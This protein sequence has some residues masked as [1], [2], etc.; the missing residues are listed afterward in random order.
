MSLDRS[1]TYCACPPS[2]G[3]RPL[4]AMLLATACLILVPAFAGAQTPGYDANLE[5]F[6]P[7][8]GSPLSMHDCNDPDNP[9]G[10]C[11]FEA[12]PPTLPPITDWNVVDHPVPFI[13]VQT[14]PPGVSAGFGFFTTAPT[15][16]VTSLFIGF[17]GGGAGTIEV[18]QDVT[19][20]PGSAAALDFDYR[21]AWDLTFGAALDRTF[22]VQVQPSG[23]GAALQ[24]DLLLTAPAGDTNTDTG[25]LS[26]TVDLSP[27]TGQTVRIAFV[28]NITENFTGPGQIEL[29]NVLITVESVSLVEIPTLSEV[30]LVVMVL[31]LAGVSLLF[32]RR[33]RA[34]EKL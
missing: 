21:G 10:N 5:Q 24:S 33:R 3:R 14:V 23:G 19:I 6:T 2:G 17:D 27:Y 8:P 28:A 15:E 26:A 20:E 18:S 32:L 12:D 22:E 4:L 25:P 16:G 11:G 9:V 7:G 1:I 29:D 31:L 34:A 13:P 30:G